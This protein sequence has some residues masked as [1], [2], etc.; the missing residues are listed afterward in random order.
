MPG[1][2]RFSGSSGLI[3]IHALQAAAVPGIPTT[4]PREWRQRQQKPSSVADEFFHFLGFKS[5]FCSPQP[6]LRLQP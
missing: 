5:R 1:R 6:L 3:A 4:V 2:G